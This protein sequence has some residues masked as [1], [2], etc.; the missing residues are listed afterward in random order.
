MKKL[1]SLLL[2][3]ILLVGCS[4]SSASSSEAEWN[5]STIYT[6][7]PEENAY[8]EGTH[9]SVE[10]MLN[11]GTGV[12]FFG[13]PE[14]PWCQKYVPMLNEDAQ[15]VGVNILYYNIYTDK[16]ED[17]EWYDSI[18]QLLDEKDSSI[19]HYDNDGNM[20]IY[21]PLV[22]FVND[23][24][25]IGYDDESCDLDSNEISVDDYWTEEKVDALHERL[26]SL[27]SVTKTNQDA[28]NAEGCGVKVN[29]D[30]DTDKEN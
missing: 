14:C 20:V 2:C 11:H 27:L 9:D 17:R 16:T 23:G 8:Y 18:A 13:F 3:S 15:E 30:C 25:I 1:L 19:T 6:D 4:S 22:I 21:M 24:E 29:P 28:G 26:S 10:K 5:L 12:I 7:L